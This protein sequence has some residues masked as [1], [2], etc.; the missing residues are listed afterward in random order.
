MSPIEFPEANCH[1]GPPPGMTEQQVRGVKGFLGSVMGGS[2]DGSTIVVV[3]W[4]PSPE[5][6][7]ALNQGGAIYVSCIGG[8]PPHFLCTSF[9]EAIGVA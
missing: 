5:D 4:R 2:M 9:P 8:L 6:L 3:A 1:F 7:Q